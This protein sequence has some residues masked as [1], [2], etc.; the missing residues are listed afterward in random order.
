MQVSMFLGS[1][2]KPS[3]TFRPAW[4][5]SQRSSHILD[6]RSKQFSSCCSSFY[7]HCLHSSKLSS[8][9]LF[10]T[11][12]SL[13]IFITYV[14]IY[15]HIFT[16]THAWAHMFQCTYF[17]VCLCK[18]SKS[19]SLSA[20][21]FSVFKSSC[22]DASQLVGHFLVTPVLCSTLAIAAIC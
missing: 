10:A 22:I 14:F 17:V 18:A 6:C 15:T 4:E 12:L 20:L 3:T 7:Q 21:L 13:D 9:V 2:L 16:H 11:Y 8:F 5:G 19:G 1:H